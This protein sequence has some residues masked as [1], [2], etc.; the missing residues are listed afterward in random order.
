MTRFRRFSKATFACT[1]VREYRES[2]SHAR[3]SA[4]RALP[5]EQVT[6]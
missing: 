6:A 2:S 4:A 3:G 1:K 5:F